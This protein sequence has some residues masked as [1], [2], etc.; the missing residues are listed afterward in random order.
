MGFSLFSILR[1]L[2]PCHA[3]GAVLTVPVKPRGAHPA[4]Q[5]MRKVDIDTSN[6][7]FICSGAFSGK[8]RQI[9]ACCV[10]RL[11]FVA[12][13]LPFILCR[14]LSCFLM[15]GS[16]CFLFL[17]P[18][19][20]VTGIDDVVA[21][22]LNTTSIG[23]DAPVGAYS[24]ENACLEEQSD[25]I[26]KVE[27]LDLIEYGL[28]PEFVGRFHSIRFLVRMLI[29]AWMHFTHKSILLFPCIPFNRLAPLAR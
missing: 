12:Y 29:F 28:S 5:M 19:L 1:R 2:T 11:R 4:K 27:G 15:P 13:L 25:L 8:F 18:L 17:V 6:I 7:L 24:H 10:Y 21:Q 26:S 20:R 9:F 3:P 16:A 23:F 14:M 22:R